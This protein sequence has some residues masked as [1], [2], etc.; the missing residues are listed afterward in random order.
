MPESHPVSQLPAQ[1]TPRI[2]R[3]EVL[4]V[5]RPGPGMVRVRFGGPDLHDYPTTGIGDEYV[6]M[7]F[8]D[9]PDEEPRLPRITHVRGWEFPDGVEPSQMRVY[10]I[11]EH[12]PGEVAVDFV[13]HDGGVAAAWAQQ[14]QP[15]RA[16]GI[17]PPWSM[18][19]KPAEVSRQI[20]LADEPGMPA[21]LRIAELT[22]DEVP[23][24]LVL[25]VRGPAHHR[26]ATIENAEYIWLDGTG[27]GLGSSRILETLRELAPRNDSY[28]WAATERRLNRAVRRYLRH[29]R[30]LPAENYQCVAYWQEKA[31]AWQSRYDTM[32]P[33]FASRIRAARTA[34]NQDPE[35]LRDRIEGLYESVGL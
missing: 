30:K 32:G 35:E 5:Q 29:E 33:A 7:F 2:H 28:V 26:Y 11:R 34:E 31:E 21:A 4:A 17:N 3:A 15:G 8:P 23:T 27:N 14:A 9:R 25:E 20:L 6:R 22:D 1:Y 24:V 16:V 19:E 12:A 18:Y 13:V 10:T